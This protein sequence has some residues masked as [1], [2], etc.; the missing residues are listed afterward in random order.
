MQGRTELNYC[1]NL[2]SRLTKAVLALCLALLVGTTLGV[3]EARIAYAAPESAVSVRKDRR[4]DRER[5]A[6]AS[7]ESG[8]SGFTQNSSQSSSQ[9]SSNGSGRPRLVRR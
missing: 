5:P 8:T 4:P 3:G 1:T 7:Q 2:K 6:P 9:S